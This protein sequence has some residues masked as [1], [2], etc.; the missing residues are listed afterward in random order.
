[1]RSDTRP[2]PPIARVFFALLMLASLGL[3]L[4][5]IVGS[6]AGTVAIVRWLLNVFAICPT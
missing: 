3:T 6:F 1:M 5:L 2:L 4:L